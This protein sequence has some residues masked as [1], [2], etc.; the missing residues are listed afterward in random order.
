VYDWFDVSIVNFTVGAT[1][2]A[3][4]WTDTAAPQTQYLQD[5]YIILT[6]PACLDDYRDPYPSSSTCVKTIGP[7]SQA[8]RQNYLGGFFTG[9]ATRVFDTGGW[10]LSSAFIQVMLTTASTTTDLLGAYTTII[11]NIAIEMT[12]NI[13]QQKMDG[14]HDDYAEGYTYLW[15]MKF[16]IRWAYMV[17]PALLVIL[18]AVFL[19]LTIIKSVGHE[20][21]KSSS[22]PLLFH[23]L[24]TA[25]AHIPEDLTDMKD[26][27]STTI[28]HLEKTDDVFSQFL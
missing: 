25:P 15:I 8:A 22:L 2:E 20:K 16:H 17:I 6:P 11:Q 9:S 12:N 14:V 28:V 23:G 7:Y 13:R 18:S 27:A 10:N 26:V 21:W 4:N 1:G 19:I 24:K 3:I 5:D